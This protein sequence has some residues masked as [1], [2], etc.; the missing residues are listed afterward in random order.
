MPKEN[1]PPVREEKASSPV[2][3]DSGGK[4]AAAAAGVETA[5]GVKEPTKLTLAPPSAPPA[6][7]VTPP[8]GVAETPAGSGGAVLVG[9]KRKPPVFGIGTANKVLAVAVLA[10][11]CL[12]AFEIRA[13]V[14]GMQFPTPPLAAMLPPDETGNVDLP[15]MAEIE[16][17]F[18]ARPL[19]QVAEEGTTT[20]TAPLPTQL[21]EV[22]EN[23]RL[24]GTSSGTAG[25]E[26]IFSD[27]KD[28]T[29]YFVQVGQKIIFRGKELTLE[30]NEADSAVFTDGKNRVTVK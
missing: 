16:K 20:N 29:M 22:A 15:S 19:F 25:V 7:S 30:K 13:N 9:H 18:E 27:R 6:P 14:M 24:K 4:A 10:I 3:P 5:S 2:K 17:R 23:L 21:S 28:G 12:A 11:I 26:L 1:P 8:A